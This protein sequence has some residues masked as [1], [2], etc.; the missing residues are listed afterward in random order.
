MLPESV[1]VAIASGRLFEWIVLLVLGEALLLYWLWRRYT[2]GLPWRDTIGSFASGACLMLAIRA[3]VLDRSDDEVAL[4]LGLSLIAHLG[5]L[6][7]R[8]R[9][10]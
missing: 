4:W 8:F 1:T 3:A 2:V 9:R 5:D 6:A 10:G 7:L